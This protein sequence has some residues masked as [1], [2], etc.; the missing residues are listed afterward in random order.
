MGRSA[1]GAHRTKAGIKSHAGGTHRVLPLSY[2][3]LQM[4]PIH[5]ISGEPAKD[6]YRESPQE[7]V[8]RKV[9]DWPAGV[10]E[11][12]DEAIDAGGDGYS[13]WMT[14]FNSLETTRSQSL[15]ST[16]LR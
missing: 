2:R 7:G 9:R 4:P 11:G 13:S 15:P 10:P 16:I 5:R 14:S 1:Q 8:A 6:W 3:S 12:I